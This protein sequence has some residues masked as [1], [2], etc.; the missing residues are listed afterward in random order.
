MIRRRF[1]SML[2]LLLSVFLALTGMMS[3]KSL[4]ISRKQVERQHQAYLDSLRRADSLMAR[5]SFVQDSIRRVREA[6]D[7]YMRDS[8]AQS[9]RTIYGG[10]TMMDRRKDIDKQ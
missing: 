4:K 2:T 3:C 10:P 5:E 7:R 6:Y 9:H 1:N 8:I